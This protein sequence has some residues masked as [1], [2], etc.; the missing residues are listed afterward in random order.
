M[1]KIEYWEHQTPSTFD[2][3]TT[4]ETTPYGNILVRR[5]GQDVKAGVF[6]PAN[7]FLLSPLAARQL[8][9]ALNEVLEFVEG[10]K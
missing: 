5:V 2:V 8:I 4:V 1:V 9:G 3:G 6:F 7:T 10:E